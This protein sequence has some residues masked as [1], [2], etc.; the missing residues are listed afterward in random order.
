MATDERA[1][2]AAGP[3]HSRIFAILPAAGLSRRMGQP[4]LLLPLGGTAVIARLLE[5]LCE[6]EIVARVVVVRPADQPLQELLAGLPAVTVV[7]PVDPPDMRA[8]V[9]IG[10]AEIERRYQPRSD[11]AWLMI[12]A[13]HPLLRPATLHQLLTVWAEQRPRLLLPTYQG[14]GG[15]PLLGR[16]DTL[17]QLRGLPADVG[18]NQLLRVCAEDV[19]RWPVDDPGVRADLD[20]PADY[21]RMQHQFPQDSTA[22]PAPIAPQSSQP[23]QG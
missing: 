14:R 2:R 3:E 9:E 11:D 15:H 20:S 4:K 13:D 6:P 23:A 12:P 22:S 5:V 8:S 21:Q 1:D 17:A 16:W 10:L 19:L 18:L 7:P